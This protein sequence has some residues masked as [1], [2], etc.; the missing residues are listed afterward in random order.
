MGKRKAKTVAAVEPEPEPVTPTKMSKKNKNKKKQTPIIAETPVEIVKP[1]PKKNKSKTEKLN[2][3]ILEDI[4][5]PSRKSKGEHGS[6]HKHSRN[7]SVSEE[8]TASSPKKKHKKEKEHKTPVKVKDEESEEEAMCDELIPPVITEENGDPEAEIDLLEIPKADLQLLL[9]GIQKLLPETESITPKARTKKLDWE[10]VAFGDYTAERCVKIWDAIQKRQ[11]QYRYMSELIED[12]LVWLDTPWRSAKKKATKQ[13]PDFPKRPKSAFLLFLQDAKADIM[14]DTK[15]AKITEI[16]RIGGQRYK[17]LS[18]A[19]KQSYLDRAAVSMR[20][21]E[22]KVEQFYEK[23]PQFKTEV[24]QKYP[25]P[26]KPRTAFTL[27]LEDHLSKEEHVADKSA[28]KMASKQAWSKMSAKQKLPWIKQA[29]AEHRKY[30]DE[31]QVYNFSHPTEVVKP[32]KTILN[33]EELQ[34]LNKSEGK[35]SKPPTS[36]YILFSQQLMSSGELSGLAAKDRV[37]TIAAKWNQVSKE[38]RDEY[39]KKLKVIQ[40]KYKKDYKVYLDKLP[41]EERAQLELDM[42][43]KKKEDRESE[44]GEKTICFKT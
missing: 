18:E 43:K 14:R 8:S 2:A 32:L 33:K 4:T 23:H 28:Y 31:V 1:S 19:A 24:V 27:F 7:D 3:S 15:D 25:G 10:K 34:M 39:E 36:A 29:V 38:D 13:H 6:H 9:N 5:T 16:A 22:R 17:Q 42:E 20:K 12:A 44:E 26:K 37:K 35:P 11:R 40:E 30:L 21:Y 41:E